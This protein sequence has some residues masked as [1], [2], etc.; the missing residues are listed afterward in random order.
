MLTKGSLTFL[1][2]VYKYRRSIREISWKRSA[3]TFDLFFSISNLL[4]YLKTVKIKKTENVC[5]QSQQIPSG[6]CPQHVRNYRYHHHHN[7]HSG[8]WTLSSLEHREKREKRKYNKSGPKG[9][10]LLVHCHPL[11]YNCSIYKE[12]CPKVGV[13]IMKKLVNYSYF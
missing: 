2:L 6:E 7:H 1:L 9:T 11:H 12:L 13:F 4:V 10:L 8:F 5:T 3:N